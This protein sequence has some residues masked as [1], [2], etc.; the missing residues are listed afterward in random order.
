MVKIGIIGGSGLEKIDGIKFD[1]ETVLKTPYGSPS[2]PYR[3]YKLGGCLFYVIARHGDRH[4]LPPHSINYRANIHGF[5]QLGVSRIV[6]FS[7]VGG[8]NP[9]YKIGSMVLADNAID[10]TGGRVSSFYDS[11]FCVHI[12]LTN[13]FCRDLRE[14][15]KE[16]ARIKGVALSDGG[17]YLCTNGPRF[18]TSAEIKMFAAMGADMVGMTMFPEVAL[19]R[20]AEICYAS[21]N[22]I[23]NLAAGLVAEKQLTADEVTEIGT[24]A[25]DNVHKIIS[26]LSEIQ[27]TPRTCFCKHALKGSFADK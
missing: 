15:I 20:E 23:T 25:A 2:S 12:D 8:I 17:V 6:A 10:W 5:K 22:T 11:G 26:G 4:T 27:W 24:K 14:A 16:A 18:E 9:A 3:V 1:S 19:A 21:I 7:A 13:P